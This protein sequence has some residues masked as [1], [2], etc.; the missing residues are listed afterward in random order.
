MKKPLSFLIIGLFAFTTTFAQVSNTWSVKFSNAIMT[1]WNTTPVGGRVCIDKM[2]SKGWEYSNSIV[3]HG[4]EKVYDQVNDVNYLNY[5]KAYVDDYVSAAGAITGMAQSL[6]RIHP[7]L[8][9]L[10][11]YQKTGLAKYKIAADTLRNYLIAS[12]STY[13]KTAEGGYWHKGTG[14][15]NNIMMLDGIYMA[16]PFI[17]KYGKMF[18]DNLCYDV[19]T[20]QALLIASHLRYN[21]TS[22][23][24]LKHAFDY[25]KTQPWCNNSTGAS[26][27]SWSRG[28]GWYMMALADILKYLP[29]SHTNYNA[30]KTLFQ[31]LSVGVKATQDPTT[32]LWY[33]VVDKG[34]SAG[35]YLE[36]SG[37]AMF[38]YAIK[39]GIDSG[40]LSSATYKAVADSGWAGLKTYTITTAGDGMPQINNFAPAMGVL[41]GA[42]NDSATAYT[43][44]VNTAS[45]DC[46]GSAHPHGYAAILMAAAVMEFPLI[47]LP[48]HFI[49]FTA[50]PFSD[51]VHLAWENGD[52]TEVDHYE[53]ERSAN[54]NDFTVIGSVRS[55]GSSRYGWDDNNPE[56]KT[57]YYRI[58]AVSIDGAAHY[59]GILPVTQKGDAASLQVSPNPVR[60]GNVNLVLN[61]INPGKYKVKIINSAGA[62]ISSMPVSIADDGNAVITLLLP[63]GIS[64]GLYY[65][66]LE[67]SELKMNRSILV[68]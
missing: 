68:K 44:Y 8:L 23:P 57:V 59:S 32:H 9:C 2:T 51:K 65:V 21:N 58:K 47:T 18:N 13:P 38:V 39:T 1:R 28:F 63:G 29:S 54:G 36:T 6:D 17:V 11:L 7:G 20:Q 46:P 50:K 66:Q 3:L 24:L 60:D 16:W 5:I 40:W 22:K 67:G 14:G 53:I 15:Y 35:N 10:F 45:V 25:T 30:M 34:G 43:A 12:W 62:I 31:D 55:T 61:S 4:M 33:Q 56:S 26:Y 49:S 48:V 52:E 27:I 42:S 19:A 41:T 37:S 64:K